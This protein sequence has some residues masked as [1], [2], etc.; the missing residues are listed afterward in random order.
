MIYS[1]V[2]ERFLVTQ[3]KGAV[4]ILR[5]HGRLCGPVRHYVARGIALTA[6]MKVETNQACSWKPS[7]FCSARGRFKQATKNAELKCEAD[8]ILNR[9]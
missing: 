6:E 3:R 4:S 9:N 5:R 1:F 2:K 7:L 8:Y